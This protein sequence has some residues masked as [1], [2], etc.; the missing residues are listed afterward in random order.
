MQKI[1]ERID[2]FSEIEEFSLKE[3]LVNLYGQVT[4]NT[5][6]NPN[7]III[8]AKSF[9]CDDE[10]CEALLIVEKLREPTLEEQIKSNLSELG[11]Q[12]KERLLELLLKLKEDENKS[13]NDPIKQI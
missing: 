13:F 3:L 8:R 10:D 1:R 12:S 7:D 9:S 4:F 6:P 2:I 5:G 11:K